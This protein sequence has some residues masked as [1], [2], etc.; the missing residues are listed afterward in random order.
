MKWESRL[1]VF[2]RLSEG[3]ESKQFFIACVNYFAQCCDLD[4]LQPEKG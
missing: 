4:F 2:Q 1:Q 3:I